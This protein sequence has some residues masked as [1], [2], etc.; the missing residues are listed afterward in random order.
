MKQQTTESIKLR[1][2]TGATKQGNNMEMTQD[3]IRI[4]EYGNLYHPNY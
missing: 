4:Y 3:P 2:G 1:R